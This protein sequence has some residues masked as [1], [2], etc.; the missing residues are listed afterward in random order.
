MIAAALVT[1]S[2]TISFLYPRVNLRLLQSLCVF[3]S[4]V[5][6]A[7]HILFRPCCSLAILGRPFQMASFH[8]WKGTF[9][10]LENKTKKK[11]K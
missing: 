11:K 7:A 3:V 4:P 1:S 8:I 5:F 10:V 2:Q 9:R 6:C